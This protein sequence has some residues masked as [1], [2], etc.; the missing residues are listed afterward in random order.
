MKYRMVFVGLRVENCLIGRL[1]IANT[2]TYHVTSYGAISGKWG[3]GAL[4]P[5]KYKVKKAVRLDRSASSAYAD[6]YGIKWWAKIEPDGWS[7]NRTGLGI[8]PDGSVPGTLGC[9]GITDAD[10][11]SLYDRLSEGDSELLVVEI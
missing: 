10:T 7:T 11:T 5:G 9:I 6:K 2:E 3:Q 1:V 4:P 8:H